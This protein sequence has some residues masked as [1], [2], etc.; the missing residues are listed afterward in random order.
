MLFE[1]ITGEDIAKHGRSMPRHYKGM[2]RGRRVRMQG[3]GGEKVVCRFSGCGDRER[4]N[5]L[6]D[7]GLVGIADDPGHAGECGQLFGG[8][9]GVTAGDDNADGRVGGVKLSNGVA[10]LSVGGGRDGAG[11]DDD[12]VGGGGRGGGDTTTV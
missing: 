2:E 3:S 7:L 11:V 6:G 1:N 12:D 10:G 4:V 8:A 5:Q 9:L